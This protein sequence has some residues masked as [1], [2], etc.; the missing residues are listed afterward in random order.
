[1]KA[2]ELNAFL[3]SVCYYEKPEFNDFHHTFSFQA[4]KWKW[5]T[6]KIKRYSNALK[7]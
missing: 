3:V 2:L 5:C 4:K 1:M 7:L 6:Q